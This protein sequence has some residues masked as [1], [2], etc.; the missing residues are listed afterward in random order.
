MIAAI[1]LAAGCS[2]RIPGHKLLIPLGAKTVIEHAV[3]NVL[4]SD[5]EEIIVVLGYNA[6]VVARVL[7]NRRLQLIVN[8]EFRKGQ[9]ASIHKGLEAVNSR[10]EAV[11]FCLGDQPFVPPSLINKLIAR[12]RENNCL[13]VY[14]QYQGQRG[15][16]VLF[17]AAL[18]PYMLNIKGDQGGR[19]LIGLAGNRACAVETSCAGVVF[20]IDVAEDLEKARSFLPPD[21]GESK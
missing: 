18:L 15:N 14:P 7:K 20:D 9:S 8:N 10:A 6:P 11:L 12:F 16:P 1:V 2:S 17:S 5:V 19:S 13:V 21:W 3:D 4:A